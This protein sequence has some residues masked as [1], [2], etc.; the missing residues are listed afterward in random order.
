MPAGVFFFLRLL[1][2]FLFFFAHHVDMP[3][4][5]LSGL[6]S[7]QHPTGKGSGL[8]LVQWIW[9]SPD[10]AAAGVVSG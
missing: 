1:L 8:D 3:S 6:P 2:P 9:I 5:P 10:T 4:G 7:C